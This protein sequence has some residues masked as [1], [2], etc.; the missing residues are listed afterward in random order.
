MDSNEV[1]MATS[2][3][4]GLALNQQKILPKSE[5]NKIAF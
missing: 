3:D 1:K 5:E 2:P 4:E